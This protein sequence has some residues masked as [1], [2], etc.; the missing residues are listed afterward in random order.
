IEEVRSLAQAVLA[1]GPA[2]FV[3]TL[4]DPPTIVVA[5]SDP[6]LDAGAALKPVLAIHGGRGGG[7]ARI[8]QGTVSDA[9]ALDAAVN[10]FQ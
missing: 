8:A 4:P 7:N 6:A 10:T 3:G 2:L 5:S 9:S 1:L